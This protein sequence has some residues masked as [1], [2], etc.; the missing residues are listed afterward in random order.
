MS[1]ENK[2]SILKKIKIEYLII[3]ILLVVAVYIFFSSTSVNLGL[4]KNN[5][6]T[7]SYQNGIEEKLEST[8]SKINGVGDCVVSVS[9]DGSGEEVVLKN[10]ETKTENGVTTQSSTAVIV[11]GKPYVLKELEP[12]VRG[13]VVVCKGADNLS[14]KMAITEVLTTILNVSSDNI[15]ILKMK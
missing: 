10:S 11:N 1:K 5:N 3:V 2:K 9:F 14:V 4:S 6:D 15:R 7:S 12:K 13:V 8:L